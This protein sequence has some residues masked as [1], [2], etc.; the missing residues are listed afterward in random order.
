MGSFDFH[1]ILPI[2][3]IFCKLNSDQRYIVIL[4]IALMG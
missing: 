4:C 2:K 1:Q 3:F